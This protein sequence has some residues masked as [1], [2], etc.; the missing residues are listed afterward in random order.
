VLL[1]AGS[2]AAAC[3][4]PE[5]RSTPR[6]ERIVLISMD[7]VRYDVFARLLGESLPHLRRIESEGARFED[8][9]AASSFTIPSHM[10]IFTGLDVA[11]HGVGTGL[12]VPGRGV[13]L[14]AEKLRGEGYET[15]AFHEGGYM[16]APYGFARGFSEYRENP[17]KSVVGGNLPTVLA[18]IRDRGRSRYFLFVHTYAAHTPLGGYDRYRK[19]HP[20]RG[21]PPQEALRVLDDELHRVQREGRSIPIT[22]EVRNLL[23]LYK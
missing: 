19:A 8:F 3:R 22:D 1:V 12:V 18:W 14:L 16:A 21:L 9:Y 13:P 5:S 7:T 4:S 20:E 10:S 6:P 17:R 15:H 11:E 2:V 23:L